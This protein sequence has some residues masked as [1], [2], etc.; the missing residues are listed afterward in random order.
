[1]FLSKVIIMPKSSINSDSTIL[2]S[3]TSVANLENEEIVSGKTLT[4]VILKDRFELLESIGIGGMG[5]V[6]KALDRRDLEAG[7]SQFIAI[8]VLHVQSDKDTTLL[9]ALHSETR[10]TQNLA[11][12]N[13]IRVYDFD[14]DHHHVFMTMEYMEGVS[15][16]KIIR[17][18]PT[19]LATGK[20]LFFISQLVQ[21]LHYAHSQG[22][23]HSDLK[24]T[25]VLVAT[26]DHLK[27]LDFG[28]SRLLDYNRTNAFDAG[29]ISAHTP[30]YSTLEMI[31][32]GSPDPRDD[33]YALA[34]I[35]YEL[36]T[37]QH[38]FHRLNAEQAMEQGLEPQANVV[39]S[40]LQWQTIKQA[41]TF[42]RNHRLAT[43]NEF[44]QGMQTENKTPKNR[45]IK[46]FSTLIFA[47]ISLTFW[48]VTQHF[49]KPVRQTIISSDMV[50][51]NMI[52]DTKP[53][54]ESKDSRIING[55]EAIPQFVKQPPNRP[56][57][58]LLN[59]NQTQF[60]LGETLKITFS[61]NYSAYIRIVLINSSGKL[62]H[63][64]PNPFQQQYYCQPNVNYQ[65]PPADAQFKLNIQPPVGRDKI[66]AISSSVPFSENF[67]QIN[68]QGT[69][70]RKDL[71]E[72]FVFTEKTYE[73][74]VSN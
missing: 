23:I 3:P 52:S 59:L 20:V 70:L 71:P 65:I 13:I 22:L 18:N 6:Y 56:S 16:D 14:R 10:K 37:G 57:K 68:E 11:H 64:F 4:G 27:V 53:S 24:P 63:L 30:A 62:I 9:K 60:K 54:L 66:I 25:N 61:V 47:F 55:I 45:Y 39:F 28:I 32:N 42:D 51:D 8:K 38:P 40:S 17:G 49:I 33:I 2:D 69:S 44:W 34:C 58:L 7:S 21:A 73:I 19:G 31:H 43:V 12:A 36:F 35:C 50:T 48:F 26:D 46:L 29:V 1:M 5:S 74:V 67:L 41:L 72:S 15:L